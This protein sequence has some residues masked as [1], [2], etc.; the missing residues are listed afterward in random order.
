MDGGY[1]FRWRKDKK[2]TYGLDFENAIWE[3]LK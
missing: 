3:Y 2:K 1:Y